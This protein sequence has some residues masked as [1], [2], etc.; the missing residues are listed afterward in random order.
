MSK[1][2]TQI[3][4]KRAASEM[5]RLSGKCL[6]QAEITHLDTSILKLQAFHPNQELPGATLREFRAAFQDLAIIH[7]TAMVEAALLLMRFE[8]KFF[9]HPA[10][11]HQR[12][13]E[14]KETEVA[15]ER[16][17]RMAIARDEQAAKDAQ[18]H[19]DIRELIA[20]LYRRQ[21]Q[22][23]LEELPPVEPG[24][25]ALDRVMQSFSDGLAAGKE[26]EPRVVEEIREWERKRSQ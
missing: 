8:T 21:G 26:Y 17:K 19:V 18:E 10:E 3:Q 13:V 12:I 14:L 20:E 25:V 16:R 11:I 23:P 9:P 15:E 5:Q 4:P 7:G 22:K 24:Y 1:E 2:P 6:S